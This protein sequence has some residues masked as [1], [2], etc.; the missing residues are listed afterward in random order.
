MQQYEFQEVSSRPQ[1]YFNALK[2]RTSTTGSTFHPHKSEAITGHK[3]WRVFIEI[4]ALE[5]N[6]WTA[7]KK[8]G[9]SHSK[10]AGNQPKIGQQQGLGLSLP[11]VAA[12]IWL[13]NQRSKIMSVNPITMFLSRHVYSK[14]INS[15]KCTYFRQFF[16]RPLSRKATDHGQYFEITRHDSYEAWLEL[17]L[18]T[19]GSAVRRASCRPLK[20]PLVSPNCVRFQPTAPHFKKKKKKKKKYDQVYRQYTW[21]VCFNKLLGWNFD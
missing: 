5:V 7:K 10:G 20:N 16:N 17:E 21:W 6:S 15:T 12:K 18:E 2:T 11:N 4:P 3:Q 13:L 9:S 14:G 1:A 19:L 8:N